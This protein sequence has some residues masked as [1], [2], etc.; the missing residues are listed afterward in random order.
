MKRRA[1]ALAIAG[2]WL[3]IDLDV[4]SF[5]QAWISIGFTIVIIGAL[6]GALFYGPQTKKVAAEAAADGP[7]APGVQLR[8]NRIFMVARIELVL[9]F[10]AVYAMVFK[11]GL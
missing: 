11:P 3:V 9:L 8:I 10:I 6:L 1:A 4:Y 5:D 2:L 7:D